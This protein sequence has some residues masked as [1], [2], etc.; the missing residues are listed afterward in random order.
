[1]YLSFFMLIDDFHHLSTCQ[2]DWNWVQSDSQLGQ[3]VLTARRWLIGWLMGAYPGIGLLNWLCTSVGSGSS[4][5]SRFL[6]IM[7]P[8]SHT[9]FLTMSLSMFKLSL[10]SYYSNSSGFC[11]YF[12]T[13]S[14]GIGLAVWSLGLSIF[15]IALSIF[16]LALSIKWLYHNTY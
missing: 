6:N 9:K 3:P 10:Q 11:S 14:F 7:S 2:L 12:H 13:H 15:L 1:M 4:S 8:S 16:Y 5:Q